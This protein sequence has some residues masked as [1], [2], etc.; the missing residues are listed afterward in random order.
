[1]RMFS[2]QNRLDT[3]RM[4]DFAKRN[5][6]L[7]VFVLVF[8]VAGTVLLTRSFA[9]S[10]TVSL[11][12]STNTPK[13][14]DSNDAQAVELGFKFK[15]D[16]AGSVTGVRFYKSAANTGTHTGSLWSA[17]GSRLATVT[18]SGESKSGWQSAMFSSP[19]AITANAT[20]VVS[21]Y[22]PTGHYSD[23]IGGFTS[24][25]SSTSLHALADG[26]SGPNGVYAYGKSAFPT[27][28]WKATNYWVDVMFKPASTSTTP[29][30][31]TPPTTTPPSTP[32]ATLSVDQQV[33]AHSNSGSAITA[34]ALSTSAAN[35]LLVA[36]VSTDSSA[37]NRG[38]TVTDMTGGGLTWTLRQRSNSQG[39]T[40]EIWQ[41]VAAKQLAAAQVKAT[42]SGSFAGSMTVTAFKGADITGNGAVAAANATMGAPQVSLT[43]TRNGSWVWGAGNDY[44]NAAS[45]TVG[46]S[47][48]LV[49][50]MLASVGDTY[51]VQRQQLAP[52]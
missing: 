49:D 41:A 38:A 1:M 32:A 31:T 36:F 46:G 33:T 29:P 45:R 8:A 52:K 9:D 25:V 30:T 10:D 43:T 4:V 50:Q 40:T 5:M 19:V 21:Y 13:E 42:L 39:G 44:D 20:Y 12:S 7:L 14:I 37:V 34:P 51:W 28:G 17:S 3:M 24:Q 15:S 22:T 11:F 48:V 27:N 6:A 47:Q 16:V 35:A 26:A 2:D 23:N 18:F